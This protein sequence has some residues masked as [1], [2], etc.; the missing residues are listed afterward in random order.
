MN[1]QDAWNPGR[2]KTD[3][4]QY[5][6]QSEGAMADYPLGHKLWHR[7][8]EVTVT[9]NPYPLFG[10]MFQDATTEEGR[11]VQVVPPAE[12]SRLSERNRR[13]W[14]EQQEGFRRLHKL[15]EGNA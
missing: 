7:G 4:T 12:Q 3:A 6:Q 10:G 9:S 2:T 14:R 5:L 11:V 8:D 15:Q 13:E 1:N